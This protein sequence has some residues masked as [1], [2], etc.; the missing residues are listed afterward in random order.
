MDQP[1]LIIQIP[2][3]PAAAILKGGEPLFLRG[4]HKLP[5]GSVPAGDFLQTFMYRTLAD[6][7]MPPEGI[8]LI[9]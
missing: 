9:A 1:P 4:V 7:R 3:D 2:A 8:I 5:Y 6:E